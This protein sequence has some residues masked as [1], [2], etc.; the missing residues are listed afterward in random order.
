VKHVTETD[1][2][3]KVAAIVFAATLIVGNT[4]QTTSETTP[5]VV[6]GLHELFVP[7]S[8]FHIHTAP[9][10]KATFQNACVL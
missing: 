1:L 4:R 9:H 6:R 8:L 3:R 10:D 5:K 2:L 7:Y